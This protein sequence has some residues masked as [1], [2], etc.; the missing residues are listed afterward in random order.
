[1]LAD[2]F[3][4][5]S[6]ICRRRKVVPLACEAKSRE[7]VCELFAQRRTID[8]SQLEAQA[9]AEQLPDQER[10]ANTTAP[11]DRYQL[12]LGGGHRLLETIPLAQA[13]HEPRLHKW[14]YPTDSFTIWLHIRISGQNVARGEILAEMQL[15]ASIAGRSS[16]GSTAL[17]ASRRRGTASR[18]S[19]PR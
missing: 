7:H 6:P 15:S 10:L 12:R 3:E 2:S 5:L 17:P 1:D 11:V 16:R 13:S 4:S 18:V 14:P 8:A 9:R 19:E